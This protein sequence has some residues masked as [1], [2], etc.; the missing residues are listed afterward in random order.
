MFSL[1]A[2]KA[3]V[4]SVQF[5]FD[6]NMHVCASS[7]LKLLWR[8]EHDFMLYLLNFPV[9]FTKLR[10]LETTPRIMKDHLVCIM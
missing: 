4:K 5:H 6:I 3:R 2:E 1:Y 8:L 7:Y 9:C 10:N